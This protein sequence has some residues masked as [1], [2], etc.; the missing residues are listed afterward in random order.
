MHGICVYHH[1]MNASQ[2]GYSSV[3]EAHV[4]SA[5]SVKQ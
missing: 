1:E 5:V 4:S 3:A 2:I